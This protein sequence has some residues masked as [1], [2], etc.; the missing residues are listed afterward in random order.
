MSFEAAALEL[1]YRLNAAAGVEGL[2]VW[3]RFTE[4]LCVKGPAAAGGVGGK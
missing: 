1:V 2:G 4:Y 3:Q